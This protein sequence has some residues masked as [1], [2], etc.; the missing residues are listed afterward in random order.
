M[1]NN[2]QREFRKKMKEVEQKKSNH[3]PIYSY[4]EQRFEGEKPRKQYK[5]PL[6]QV[7]GI[8]SLLVL[9]WNLYAFSSHL[10]PWT[11]NSSFVSTN[12]LEVHQYI[13]ES[14]EIELALNEQI[15]SLITQYNEN[16]LTD[17]HI[18]EAQKNMF[19]LQKKME[20][21]EP[22]FLAMKSYLREQFS[23]AY[24]L[25]N[26]LKTKNSEIK[27]REMEYI[28]TNQ[29]AQSVRRNEVLVELLESEKIPYEWLENGTISYQY[30]V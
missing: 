15:R 11:A 29:N 19:E 25:T 28:I 7:G 6:V 13:Q 4:R 9:L 14:A 30:E 22:R 5:R 23:L 12:Q 16:S 3:N 20:T 17:F 10:F 2:R 8:V 26:V 24:Q 1:L 18:E 21:N 27:Y